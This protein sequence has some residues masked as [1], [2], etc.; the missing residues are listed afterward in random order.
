MLQLFYL[1]GRY[2]A[3][4]SRLSGLASDTVCLCLQVLLC[5]A[6]PSMRALGTP[7]RDSL[8][9]ALDAAMLKPSKGAG[10]TGLEQQHHH[11]QQG[12][13]H[14]HANRNCLVPQEIYDHIAEGGEQQ[15]QA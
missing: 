8:D 11:Q 2:A 7:H 10:L 4:P 12:H 9:S 3:S 13:G 6:T 1:V 5:S 15:L 14:G